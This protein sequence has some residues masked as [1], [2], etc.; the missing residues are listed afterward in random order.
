ME[1]IDEELAQ[2]TVKLQEIDPLYGT[3]GSRQDGLDKYRVQLEKVQAQIAAE[4]KRRAELRLNLETLKLHELLERV[5]QLPSAEDLV[6]ERAAHQTKLEEIQRSVLA[7]QNMCGALRAELLEQR[8]HA[9]GRVLAHLKKSVFDSIGERI[10]SVEL[11]EDEW[12]A[13]LEDGQR[14]PLASLS[15]GIAELVT[16]CLNA[17]LLTASENAEAAPLVWDDVLSQLDDM[18]L[19]IARQIIEQLARKRQVV[20]LTRDS[21]IRSWGNAVE[22]LAGRHEL[23][24]LLN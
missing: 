13:V 6:A 4:T 17:G 24:V 3:L 20:L 11:Y 19:S 1:L 14:R 15:R 16:L 2:V 5:S 12:I 23:D 22:V 21:R 7:A 9:A 10:A 18:H 8:D